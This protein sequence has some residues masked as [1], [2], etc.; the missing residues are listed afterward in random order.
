[1]AGQ[2][3]RGLVEADLIEQQGAGPW[4]SYILRV[5]RE[6]PEQ[7]APQTDEDRIVAYVA[8]RGSITNLQ[9]R[10]LLGVE[11][12][13][14]YYL[15]KARTHLTNERSYHQTLSPIRR[16]QKAANSGN[17]QLEREGN[18]GP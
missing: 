9:C 12:H 8:E 5:P 14:A 13:Q 18:S 3:L 7:R 2:E 15:L 4:T 1:M 6:L 16:S 10:E 17:L 11:E